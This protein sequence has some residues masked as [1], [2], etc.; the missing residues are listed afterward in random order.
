MPILFNYKFKR[1]SRTVQLKSHLF[2]NNAEWMVWSYCGI[3]KNN[4]AK[5]QPNTLVAFRELSDGLLSDNVILKRVPLTLLGQL[6]IGTVWKESKCHA[7]AILDTPEFPFSIDF[8]KGSWKLS[9]FHEASIGKSSPP[10]PFSIYPLH[11]SGDKNWFIEFNLPS[12]GKLVIPCIEFFSRCYGRSEEL[13]RILS[14]YPW[15]GQ[16]DSV[17]NR[18]YAPLDEPEEP[19]KW[20]VKLRRRLVNG[21]VILLAHAKYDR[22]TENAA[23][24]IYS[25]IEVQYDPKSK[26]PAFVKVAPWFQGSAQIMAKGIWF[27]DNRSFL[28]LRIIGSSDPNGLLIIRDRENSNKAINP[29]E[30][31]M[32]GE[33]W[34]GMPQRELVKAPDI[35]DLT[36]DDEPDH[37]SAAVEIQDPDFVVIGRPRRVVDVRK[38]QA[39][40]AAGPRNKGD[41]ATV[42]SSGEPQGVEKGVGYASIHAK[43]VLE[44]HGA[45]RDMWNAM[46]FLKMKYP[47]LI[48]EVDW[49]TFEDGFSIDPIPKVI[50][51]KPFDKE[52]D[53]SKDVRNWLYLDAVSNIPR[54]I[55][56]ARVTFGGK[57][58]HIIEIQRRP[59]TKKDA[60]GNVVASEEAFK[61]LA[62]ILNDS[63][64]FE[65]WLR[66]IL[67][68]VR[69][70]KGI[71]KNLVASCP[72]TAADFKHAPAKGD[73]VPCE[74]AVINA[75]SKVGISLPRN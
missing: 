48:T 59:R 12:G 46:L 27:D 10:Y 33:A 3:Y 25:Q 1:I 5:S 21:D 43:Q 24:S 70:V 52:N 47:D 2:D 15:D 37:G 45:L 69:Y 63:H 67:S 28:A 65:K 38:E 20:K 7:E 17:L 18:V 22:Y 72:G 54:G 68:Q 32:A 29:A 39:K 62:F 64:Q 49:F 34:S 13:K 36:G 58:V 51:L 60:D 26:N 9:S 4:S 41:D 74:A 8:T 44:S 42:F 53:V 19:G 23:K 61:G 40:T 14:T 71:V 31:G 35:I 30:E 75:L 50:T 73:Q 56:V 6:R 57:A 66:D 11:Y 16:K 55:L